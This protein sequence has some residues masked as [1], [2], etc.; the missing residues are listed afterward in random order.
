MAIIALDRE[1]IAAALKE[2][3]GRSVDTAT[4]L[5]SVISLSTVLVQR[6]PDAAVRAIADDLRVR[7]LKLSR[8]NDIPRFVVRDMLEDVVHQLEPRS[9]RSS[10]PL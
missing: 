2:Q 1:L 9:P 10:H 4:I 7:A 3:L 5:K 8:A 6:A